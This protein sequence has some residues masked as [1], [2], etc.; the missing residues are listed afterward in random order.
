MI[1]AINGILDVV[2]IVSL[3]CA[4]FVFLKVIARVINP[5]QSCSIAA[6]NAQR[7]AL[8][9]LRQQAMIVYGPDDRPVKSRG[10]RIHGKQQS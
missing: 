4:A 5:S 7:A 8:D 1:D 10:I 9:Q 2:V 3:G 6:N